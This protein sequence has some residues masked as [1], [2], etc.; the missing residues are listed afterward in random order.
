MGLEEQKLWDKIKSTAQ[1][2]GSK[3]QTGVNQVAQKVANATQPQQSQPTQQQPAGQTLE[4]VR[5]EWTKINSDMSNMKGFGEG[6]SKDE[7]MA[8]DMAQM[9]GRFAILKKMGKTNGSISA[10][11]VDQKLFRDAN[12]VNHYLVIM[13]PLN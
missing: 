9:N 7:S 12:G 5:A 4:Q 3:I 1:N 10:G 8:I 2:V 13:E 11:P 6:T